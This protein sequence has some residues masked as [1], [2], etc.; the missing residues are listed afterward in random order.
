[1]GGNALTSTGVVSAAGGRCNNGTLSATGATQTFSGTNFGA[2]INVN[3]SATNDVYFNGSTFGG[4][5]TVIR[6]NAGNIQ[7]TGNN[8]FNGVTSITNAGTGYLLLT[9]TAA[10]PDAFNAALTLTTSNN[11]GLYIGYTGNATLAANVT[12]NNT[13]GTGLIQLGRAA[14]GA[15][16]LNAGFTITTGSFAGANL[17]LQNFTQIGNTTLNLSPGVNGG[18]DIY[19]ATINGNVTISAGSVATRGATCA[20]TVNLTK[21]SG[22][23]SNACA[24][25]NTFAS[26]LTMNYTSTSGN[27]YWSMGNGTAD[28]YNGDVF[29]NNNSLDRIIFSHASVGNQFNGNVT[30]TQIG[31]SVGTAFAWNAGSTCTLAT[32]KTIS[33][34]GAGY[35]AGWLYVQGLTQSGS[36]AIN[37]PL[38]GTSSIFVGVGNASGPVTIGGSFTVSAPD[39]YFRGGTFNGA[40][41]ITKTGTGSD[42]NNGNLNTFNSTCTI[43]NQGSAG[44]FMLGY[45]SADAF[46]D[47]ITLTSTGAGGIN[48]GYSSGTGTP[49]LASGKTI[50]IGGAGF[51]AGSIY[52]GTFTQLGSA[53]M[54]L[55][56]SGTAAMTIALSS[57]IGGNLTYTGANFTNASSSTLSGTA[58][59]TVSGVI[60]FSGGSI[61]GGALTCT[62]ADLYFNGSTFNGTVNATKTGS[63]G[64]WGTGGNTFNGV[65]TI[66]QTGSAFLGFANGSPDIFNQDVFVNNNSTDRV[67]FGNSSAGN[68]FNGNITLTQIGSSVGIAFGWN[69]ATDMTMATGK[70]IFIGAAGFNVG[71]LQIERFT[72]LGSTAMS[73]PLTGT[74]SV[75]FGPTAIIGGNLTSTSASLLFNGC[76]FN[77]TVDAT[78]N[79]A[80][81]DNGTG[82][83]I[84][85]GTTTI[86]NNGSGQLML[87]NGSADQFNGVT[88]FNDNGSYRFVV[89]NNHPGLTTAFATDVTFNAAKTGGGVDAWSFLIGEGAST[90]LSFGGKVTINNS[91]ALQSNFRILQ[92]G[93]NTVTYAGDLTVNVTNTNISTAIQMGIAGNSTYNGNI[94]LVNSSG[95]NGVYFNV[96]LAASSTLANTKTISIGAGG[97]NSGFLSLLRFTQIGNTAQTLALTGATTQLVVGPTSAFGGNVTFTSPSLLLNGCTYSG[98]SSITK[99]GVG[100]DNSIGGNTFTGVSTIV[101]SGSGVLTLA[102]TAGMPDNFVTD[103]N[104]TNSGSGSIN[105][106][107]TA[108]GNLFGG[109]LIF[110]NTASG[111][112]TQITIANNANSG[113]SITGNLSMNNAGSGT[114]SNDIYIASSG[115]VNI[116]GT[117]TIINNGSGAGH[118]RVYIDEGAVTSSITF[119]GDVTFS[120]I[121]TAAGDVYFRN[122]RG[123]LAFNGNLIL[124]NTATTASGNNGFFFCWSGF[125]GTASLANGK[126]ITAGGS[127]FST[128]ILQLLNFTQIGS[129]AQTLTLTGTT[130][131]LII[132]PVS[133]FGASTA[134]FVSPSLYLNGCTYAGITSFTKNGTVNNSSPGGNTFAGVSTIINSGAGNLTLANTVGTPD[135]FVTHLTATNSGSGSLYLANN[136][137][138]NIFGGNLTFNNSASGAATLISIANTA[139]SSAAITGNLSMNNTGSGTTANDIYIANNGTVTIGGTTTIINNGSGAGHSRV[140]INESLAASATTFGGDATFSNISTAA[141]DVYFR[142]V[143]GVATFNGNLIVSNTAT[144]ASANNGIYFCWSIGNPGIASL[145]NTKTITV[146]GA[147]FSTGTLQLLNFTQI[148]NTVQTLNLTGTITQLIVGAGSSFGGNVIFSSPS[149]YLNGCTYA[150]TSSFTRIATGTANNTSNGGNTFTGVSSVINS[151]AGIWYF[152]N[153]VT[154][155]DNFATDLTA[156]NNGSGSLYL[157][158]NS[159]GNIFGG[160][161]IFSNTAA[162]VNTN[163]AVAYNAGA[164]ASIGGNLVLTNAATGTG[165]NYA[166]IANSGSATITGSFTATNSSSG[167]N[168]GITIAAGAAT[169]SVSIGGSLSITN[170]GS[171]TAA[172]DINIGASAATTT[173]GGT[174]A[175]INNGSGAGHSRVFLNEGSATA[176]ITYGGDATFSN[177]SAAVGDAYFRNL[178]GISTFN[179]NLIVNGTATTASANNGIY[180]CWSTGNTGSASLASGKTITVGASGYSKGILNLLNFTQIGGTAQ[181]LTLTGTANLTIGTTS[182]FGGNVTFIAPA[183]FLNGCTYSGTSSFTKNGSTN[184]ASI[185]GNTFTGVSTITNNGAGIMY[186]ANTVAAPDHFIADITANNYGSGS[187]N[188]AYNSL[189]NTFGGNVICSNTATGANNILSISANTNATS[190]ITGNLTMNNTGGGVANTLSIAN[191]AGTNVSIGGNLNMN[192]AGTGTTSNDIYIAATGTV[193]ITGTSNIINNST[194]GGH[195]R[196]FINESVA[197]ATTIFGG[198]ATLSNIS[199]AAG[200]VYFRNLRGIINFN[201]NV[202]VNNTATTASANNGFYFT[203][204][205]WTGIETLAT[206]KTITVGASGFSTGRLQLINFTQV[207]GTAQSLTLTG[208]AAL[209]YGPTSSFGGNVTS[210]SPTLLFNGCTFAGTTTCTKNGTTSDQ[211]SGNNIF[212]GTSIM[213]NSG[214]GYL[215]FGNGSR[216]QWLADVT[217]NNT[218]SNI[219]YVAH[220]STNSTFGGNVT[221]NNT[222]STGN[223]NGI[224]FCASASATANITGNLTINNNPTSGTNNSIRICD[225]NTTTFSVGGTTSITNVNNNTANYIRFGNGTTSACTFTGDV[226]VNNNGTTA[227]TNVVH[228]SY[229]GSSAFNGNIT[230][231]STGGAGV[232]FGNS[233]GTSTQANNK[234]INTSTFTGGPLYIRNFTQSGPTTGNASNV[235]ITGANQLLSFNN[236]SFYDNVTGSSQML[237]C[238]TSTFRNTAILTKVSGNANNYWTGGNTFN[239]ATTITNQS[240]FILGMANGTADA[241]NGNVIFVQIGTG[242]VS[243]NY[244]ANCT[245]AGNITVTT[246]AGS[247]MTFGAIGGGIATMNGSSGGQTINIT[248]G[249]MPIFTRF[250]MNH[251]GTG[252]T[253]NTPITISTALTMTNGQ[254]FTTATNLPILSS[255]CTASALTSASTSY[256]N[257]PMRYQKASIGATTLNF[258]IGKGSDC[259]PAALTVNHTAA[260]LNNYTAELFNTDP[261]VAFNSGS[262][263]IA[264]NMP[265][266]VDTISKVHYWNIARTDNVGASLG[267]SAGL[268]GNQQIQLYFD[269]NDVVYQGASLTIVKNTSAT[270]A[271]WIDIGGSCA[272]GNFSTPQVG[273]VTSTSSPSA[274]NSFSAFTLGSKADFGWNPLPI[275]LLYFDAKP[276]NN[277]VD[278]TWVTATETNNKF[279]TIEKSKN[280]VDFEFLQNINS[281]ALN[282]NST[283]TLNYRIYD[284]NPCTGINYYRLKQT[285]YN[286][287]YKYANIVHVNFDKKSFVSVFPNP[288]S[289]NLFVNVSNEYDNASLKFLDALGREV[290]LQNINSSNVNAINTGALFPG[291][292][293]VII[294]NESGEVSKTKI[295]IQQ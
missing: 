141:G 195:S 284:L 51:S 193:T 246:P 136:S 101:N 23:V 155:P 39:L 36:T 166:Y 283:T 10:R 259:R 181:S 80:T 79:G 266:T 147:G 293:Y 7:S 170:T 171:A 281:E 221:C 13:S 53:G 93:T 127:G 19:T 75:T 285:D 60:T 236:S 148:G 228:F 140:F 274:F 187:L 5:V 27:G 21:L 128:G 94:I 85:N 239:G 17:N 72:Q 144:T 145:A 95:A 234:T 113:A 146:G 225:G 8:I 54:N 213:N 282:G 247:A 278:L 90:N 294:V 157:A 130:T 11:G 26:T 197:S 32:G 150:G 124:N 185:G 15:V 3:P 112:S 253:L 111:T 87:G 242:I 219:I 220:N 43:N 288:A 122:L 165:N 275:E 223:N 287:K 189:G 169:T 20:G 92:G 186:L 173:I 227:S 192:N 50:S 58:T 199:A 34:G 41:T 176:S 126:T 109:N 105:L 290:L 158:H 210:V 211:G 129:T 70:T 44:Y 229:T 30:L 295:T 277:T 132:G 4:S 212:T 255:G 272:F 161:L 202:I 48:L 142:N 251:M 153:V 107:A 89:A 162:G 209:Q 6:N 29:A 38:T 63:N 139:G 180:L 269:V 61:V 138:G 52:L 241:Y 204:V 103:L 270:P 69:A 231:N 108:A 200:D 260:T 116:G 78:K 24:G 22:A 123:T 57:V 152:A 104:A 172:N 115:T 133:S 190:A 218:G 194:G 88:I 174:T 119:G 257:G 205:G 261:W 151:S 215:M 243:P 149:M 244:N 254:L 201:G 235:S 77:G 59:I 97:F 198:D 118:S 9:N 143:K 84:F 292:Y 252:V 16:T 74:S 125:P 196:V 276:V 49:T 286:G 62:G 179:S 156:I 159:P 265:Q 45:N 134:T 64:Q 168:S 222:G 46:N 206:G 154:T 164:S 233:G 262:P 230:L 240:T 175:I 25:G 40:V 31:S 249:A 163:I 267:T 68:R 214:S 28:I 263:Y 208:T 121:S 91:G 289:N 248:T 135:N 56:C 131:Q 99:T 291:I 237:D 207:G 256:V 182:A 67:I 73:L 47:N 55:P 188:L 81:G 238:I 271:A 232:V 100:T 250:V 106:A 167:T 66:N 258:P 83:N 96:N 183:M 203:W 76:T 226:T 264:T 33:I 191:G 279:F 117:T 120:N 273:S 82:G 2:N 217:Y 114:T 280:G 98:T 178:K 102:N 18:V 37:L 1:L 216:D 160:N 12:V 245:Y 110:N 65:T 86:T 224:Y 184:D 14:A 177:I 268:S 42:H 35:S 71:Y 137:A